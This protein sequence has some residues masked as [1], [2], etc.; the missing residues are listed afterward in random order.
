M[1]N[2]SFTD[3][4]AA[5]DM[6]TETDSEGPYRS[7]SVLF[8]MKCTC[9]LIK[10]IAPVRTCAFLLY[11]LTILHYHSCYIPFLNNDLRAI[12]AD[13]QRDSGGRMQDDHSLS[14]TNT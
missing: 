10:K 8:P 4:T 12:F 9:P 13:S 1:I 7:R 6:Q 14:V 11:Q 2:K 3:P 5:I